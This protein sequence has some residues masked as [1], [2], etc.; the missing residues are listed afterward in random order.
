MTIAAPRMSDWQ[1]EWRRFL[2]AFWGGGPMERDADEGD[3]VR[4]H[5]ESAAEEL[6]A[7]GTSCRGC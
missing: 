3:E 5:I 1:P 4:F 7:T 6:I 2:R